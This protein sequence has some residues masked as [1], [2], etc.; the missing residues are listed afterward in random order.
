MQVVCIDDEI[1]SLNLLEK[2]IEDIHNV[3]IKG[4]FVN[5]LEGLEFILKEDIDVAFLDIQMPHIDGLQLAEKI[6]EEKP[7]MVIVFV[8]AYN[9]FAVDAFEMNVLDYIVKP[10]DTDRLQMTMERVNQRVTDDKQQAPLARAN[11][12]RINVSPFLTFEVEPNVFKPLKWRTTKSQELFL[13]LLQN[14][15]VL[16]EKSSLIELLWDECD[17]EKGYALLYTTIYNVRKQLK[18]YH[19][20][21]VLQNRSDGYLLEL[22]NV[23]VD[24]F[25]WE[26]E[27]GKLSEVDEMTIDRFERVMELNKGPYLSSYDYIWLESERHRMDGLWVRTA[28]DMAD[29][30]AEVKRSKEAIKWNNRLIERHSTMEEAHFNLMKLYEVN[31]DFTLM[32]QQYNELT[33]VLRKELAEKPSDYIVEWYVGKMK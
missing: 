22:R 25:T 6:L 9:R 30:Y 2:K 18:D 27:L 29:Y 23:E 32:M 8:T 10:I 31:G 33:K 14:S 15:N 13:Y 19:E 3:N 7:Q 5:P 17:V 20:H 24:L 1:L 11:N 4:M 12:L 16:I 26:D 28:A 21:I